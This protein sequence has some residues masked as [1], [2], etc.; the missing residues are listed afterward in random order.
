VTRLLML[1][2]ALKSIILY[3]ISLQTLLK[4]YILNCDLRLGQPYNHVNQRR[5]FT[6]RLVLINMLISTNIASI[7]LIERTKDADKAK[8]KAYTEDIVQEIHTTKENTR[9]VIK[10]IKHSNRKSA[11]SVISQAAS[12]QSTLLRNAKEY[13]K[14]F[15]NKLYT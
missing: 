12:Q 14:D 3:Y 7:K 4:E 10:K 1:V 9:K 2:K 13:I 5:H 8:D 15:A 6:L 11:T